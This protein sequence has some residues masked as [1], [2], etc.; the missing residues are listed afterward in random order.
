MSAAIRK[1]AIMS[2]TL[3]TGGTG[4]LGRP[5]VEALRSRGHEVDILSRHPGA[6]R[7][8]GDLDRDSGLEAAV[9]SA[10]TIVHLATNRRR[11]CHGTENLLRAAANAGVE[12]V[13]YVSIVG[14][15]DI[16]YFYYR[17][18]V[19]CE[20]VIEGS[21]IPFTILRATQ[22]HSFP[23]ELIELQHRLATT[24]VLDISLQTIAV[25]E[26]AERLAELASES[27]AGRVEDVGGPEILSFAEVAEIW[28]RAHGAAKT[29]RT[30]HLGGRTVRGFRAGHHMTG[31]PGFG[32]E[33]FAEFAARAA[34]A[35]NGP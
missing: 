24:R 17:D 18:K 8:T 3:V 16:P 19:R 35:S 28:H 21:G 6:M 15:E 9:A 30:L 1:G 10:A 12:H 31:L 27:P 11:D 26:V 23:V 5:T 4:G 7:V 34:R 2:T 20:A 14:V 13:V 33:T 29:V 32:R 22:F 25:A